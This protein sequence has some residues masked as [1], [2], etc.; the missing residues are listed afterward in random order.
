[1]KKRGKL[2]TGVMLAVCLLLTSGSAGKV[3][4][5]GYEEVQQEVTEPEESEKE[6][7]N[8]A[9][10]PEETVE[11]EGKPIYDTEQ[12]RQILKSIPG[13]ERLEQEKVKVTPYALA[14]EVVN[15]QV[16][17]M[18][19]GIISMIRYTDTGYENVR[20]WSEGLLGTSSGEWVYCADPNVDFQAGA[21]QCYDAA[22]F[23]S[24]ETIKT[25]GMMF[26]YFDTQIKCAGMSNA[27]IYLIRQCLL[28]SVLNAVNGWMP[29]IT[30]A[31]GNG[32][33]DAMGH[34]LAS[35]LGA[36]L[37]EGAAW[38]AD[39]ENRK[40]I[41]CSGVLMKGNGQ[42]LSQWKYEY[43]PK[44]KLCIQKVSDNREVSENNSCYSL[45]GA[46]YGVYRDKACKNLV[47]T[48]KTDEAGKS[49]T[50]ELEKGTYYLQEIKAPKGFAINKSVE[51]LTV[52]SGQTSTVR[53]SD[54]PL[55][56]PVEV[57]LG[58]KDKDT[59]TGKPS[60]A[61]SLEGAEFSIKYYSGYYDTDP[62]EQGKTAVRTWKLKTDASGKVRLEEQYKVSGGAFYKDSDGKP[63]LPLGTV[64]IQETKAPKGYLINK[65]VFLRKIASDEKQE[66]VSA[67]N[68]PV[69]KEEV[70]RGDIQLTKFAEDK[71]AEAE[72]KVPL[73]GIKFKLTSKTNGQSWTIVTDKDGFASTKQLKL[74]THGNLVYDTYIISETNTPKEYKKLEDFEVTISGDNQT[75]SYIVENKL[76]LSPVQLVKKDAVTGNLIPAA[77]AE[78]QLLDQNKNVITM[79]TYYPKK[80]QINTFRT[81]ATGS[82]ML[83]EKLEIGTYYFRETTAPVGYLKG[84]DVSF[85]ITEGHR[86]EDPFVVEFYDQPVMGRIEI[87]KTDAE[88]GN[89]LPGTWFEVTAAEDILAGDGSMVAECG[90]VMDT[91]ET[92]EDG[93]AVVEALY[94]GKYRIREQRATGG[95]L[96]SDAEYLVTL[97]YG[98]QTVPVIVETVNVENEPTRIRLIKTDR[99]S[100]LPLE[101]V[102]FSVW[103]KESGEESAREYTTDPNG[104]I[105]IRRLIPGV[106]CI[107]EKRTQPGYVLDLATYE[108]VISEDGRIDGAETGVLKLTNSATRIIGT[109]ARDETGTVRKKMEQTD[110]VMLKNLQIGQSYLLKGIIMDK[111]TGRPLLID[112]HTVTAEKRF[113]A[114]TKDGITEVVFRYDGTSLEGKS[115]VFFEKL[116]VETEGGIVEIAAHEDLEDKNQTITYKRTLPEKTPPKENPPKEKEKKPD[117][118]KSNGSVAKT[119]D[120][121]DIWRIAVVLL[122]AAGYF[123]MHGLIRRNSVRKG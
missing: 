48:L 121:E 83:P 42:D 25:I 106:Y 115:I 95:Y 4:A 118:K 75:L 59:N 50:V 21:K 109:K 97:E 41:T 43:Y 65:E 49:N 24:A 122:I 64:T 39:A 93:K 1:M 57:V 116:Y 77:D 69:I 7:V 30:L 45:A 114:A 108:M 16:L 46:E 112:G 15:T 55:M 89:A 58:K 26:Y 11:K 82:F 28:W 2:L 32:M 123:I 13:M 110:L 37:S 87:S 3:T 107:R 36:A 54:R 92:G 78:F 90:T 72:K 111:E 105:E 63:A 31:Y 56:S 104:V 14:G 52:I 96:L 53:V 61:A 88:T 119:G 9:D 98:D 18:D 74:G 44:G 12:I 113:T 67:Y 27:D 73:E 71:D 19:I 62:A 103:K 86:W 66:S 60:G 20:M 51:N 22:D 17:Q 79:N 117:T 40:D 38:A 100:G 10:A 8:R 6:A 70:M 47:V 99:E 91:V 85:E 101:N 34:G 29:G 84:E 68:V 81:D 23:Y 102:I 94:L 120:T 76:I 35:H 33:T 80:E 5:S